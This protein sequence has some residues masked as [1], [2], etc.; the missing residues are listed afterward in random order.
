MSVL[1]QENVVLA[2]PQ[3]LS[4]GAAAAAA[5][6]LQQ[7]AARLTEYREGRSRLKAKDLV[8]L[9]LVHGARAW[10]ASQ[11]NTRMRVHAVAPEGHHAVRLR[12]A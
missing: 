1:D 5:Q 2:Y 7:A 10:R 11:P 6:P 8:G 3:K 12:L 4:T 9:L